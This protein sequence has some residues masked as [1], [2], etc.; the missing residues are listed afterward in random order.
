MRTRTGSYIARQVT[1]LDEASTE[2]WAREIASR[3]RVGRV[4]EGYVAPDSS[5]M[6]FL[7]PELGYFWLVVLGVGVVIFAAFGWTWQRARRP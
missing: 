6:S 4:A 5:H 1:P 2:S 7:I 3:Y